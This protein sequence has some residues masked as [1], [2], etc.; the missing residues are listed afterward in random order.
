M[1]KVAKGH[2]SPKDFFLHLLAMITLYASAISFTTVVY[3]YINIGIP[4]PL[5]QYF[6]AEGAYQTIRGAL[7]FLIVMFPVYLLTNWQLHKSYDHDKSKRN[8]WVRKWLV[9]FTLFVAALII[10]FD[11]VFLVKSLLDGELTLRFG[12]KLLTIFFTAGSIFGYYFWD[13]KRYKTDA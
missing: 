11:A 3:Q 1:D 7:A 2:T 13:L 12:L 9:Y 5:E 6:Y 4:D 8:I 10:I